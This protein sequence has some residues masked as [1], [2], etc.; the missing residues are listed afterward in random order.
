MVIEPLDYLNLMGL[1]K[2]CDRIITDSGGLQKEAYFGGKHAVVVMPDTSWRE[3]TD[4]GWNLL[5]SENDLYEKVM[6]GNFRDEDERFYG[7]G[8]A[9][10]KIVDLIK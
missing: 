10:E 6:S 5:A 3:L 9:C 2:K 7:N 1:M 8:D 4:S